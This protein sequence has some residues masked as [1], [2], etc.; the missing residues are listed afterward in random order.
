[1]LK[2]SVGYVEATTAYHIPHSISLCIFHMIP[3]FYIFLL[4][5]GF[6]QQ[7]SKEADQ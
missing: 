7:N 5:F 4:Y 3:L 6:H 2:P 1:M